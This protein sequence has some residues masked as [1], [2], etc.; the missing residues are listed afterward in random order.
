MYSNIGIDENSLTKLPV[1]DFTEGIPITLEEGTRHEIDN[2]ET[3]NCLEDR[4]KY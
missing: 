3:E 1:T 4:N 2:S